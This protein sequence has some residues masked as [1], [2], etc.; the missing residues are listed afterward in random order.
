MTISISYLYTSLEGTINH[1]NIVKIRSYPWD[2]VAYLCDEILVDV[3]HLDSTRALKPE[4]LGYITQFLKILLTEYFDF[5]SLIITS[6][7]FP[8]SINFLCVICIAYTT[9]VY[10]HLRVPCTR[11]YVWIINP[12]QLK[13]VGD[14]FHKGE[15]SISEFDSEGIHFDT[16]LL[17][18]QRF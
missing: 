16:W 3:D 2:N 7:L 9:I 6:R 14:C 15:V 17:I 11:D 8:L 18:Q 10:H 13:V 4:H 1:F 5:K 12:C